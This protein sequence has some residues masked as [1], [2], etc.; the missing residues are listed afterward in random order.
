MTK[1]TKLFNNTDIKIA[2]KTDV[3][4]RQDIHSHVLL[5]SINTFILFFSPYNVVQF[6]YFPEIPSYF[7]PNLVLPYFIFFFIALF[8][9][10]L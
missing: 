7:L 9:T 5:K 8:L 3:Y 10:T 4:K 2:Y 6:V 1:L